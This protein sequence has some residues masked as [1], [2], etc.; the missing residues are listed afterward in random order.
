M[1]CG[2][3]GALA[4]VIREY[5][6]L[7]IDRIREAFRSVR[8]VCYQ[9]PTGGGKTIVAAEI[10]R[11]VIANGHRGLAL[12]HRRELI[13]QFHRTLKSVDA[14]AGV[15]IGIIAA[16]EAETPWAP[17][18]IAG[19]Q[20]LVRRKNHHFNPDL[21]IVDE[22]HHI[23][24]STWA[25]IVE[26]FP[27]ARLLGLTATP[28]RQ[29][30]RGLGSHFDVLVQGPTI[31]EL[32]EQG[33]LAPC[34]VKHIPEGIDMTGA[35]L[36]AGEWNRGD[37]DRR[38]TG[39]VVAK[40]A[41][42]Y[43]RY[44]KGRKAIFFGVTVRHSRAVAAELQRLGVHAV[45][46][47]GDASSDY[48]DRVLRAFQSGSVDVICNCALFDEGFDAPGCD[49]VM[50]GAPTK[51]V[52]RYLQSCG[53]AMRPQP[54]K[55][56]LILDLAGSSHELGLPD[57]PREWTL[58]DRVV[59]GGKR[60]SPVV[61]ARTCEKC[62]EVYPVYRPACPSCGTEASTHIPQ[63]VDVELV[64][65]APRSAA[66]KRN[67][68]YVRR[69]AA[70]CRGDRKQLLALAKELGYKEGWA[71]IQETI[72]RRRQLRERARA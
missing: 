49:C 63:E 19:V 36:L 4:M 56:A 5:Q 71:F 64:D 20:T 55:E 29:D 62:R 9:L 47:G 21:I 50:L 66:P 8:S 43:V 58:E 24:A 17:F 68:G 59:K 16:G 53:R 33:H 40:A 34:R 41:Q 61:R 57:D 27:G 3:A 44:A 65:A 12:M 11:R 45:H 67:A 1:N 10:C 31:P 42:S 35:R 25:L 51:S 14:L 30:G 54:G 2:K 38:V 39:R 52:I 69:R 37:I 48:R 18:Q 60:K 70:A 22:A 13:R 72:W 32:I 7:D 15:P 23:R 26:R 46:V 6:A 28:M